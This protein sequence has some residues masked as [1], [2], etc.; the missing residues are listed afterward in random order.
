M[1]RAP[2]VTDGGIV[3]HVLNRANA[4]MDLFKTEDD[5]LQF[6]QVLIAAHDRVPMRTLGYC[7]MPNH[8]H[9]VLWPRRDGDLSAFMQWVSLTHTQRWHASRETVG[10]GHIYQGRYK[11]FPI[12]HRRPS[13]AAAAMGLLEGNDPVLSVLRYVER[14]ALRA[15]LVDDAAAWRWGSAWRRIHGLPETS[16]WLA[17]VPGGL[18]ADWADVVNRPQT[19]AELASLLHCIRRDRPYGSDR[20]VQGIARRYGLESTLRPRGRPKVTGKKGV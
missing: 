10:F 6:E 17:P 9:L 16:S 13:A 14:N 7:V 1:G 5:Y 8:W 19:D 11:S 2:R 12:Q 15:G 20:W 4:R 18:P 3:Y